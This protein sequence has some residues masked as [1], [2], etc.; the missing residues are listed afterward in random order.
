MTPPRDP[1]LQPDEVHVW[2]APL[3]VERGLAARLA[4]TL[5]SEEMAE[6][7]RFRAERHLGAFVAARGVLRLVLSAYVGE[8]PAALRV[9]RSDSGKPFLI[10]Y[11]DL[12]F[13][14]SHSGDVALYAVTHGREVGVD[15]EHVTS[16]D[17]M[18]MARRF[19]SRRE[20]DD[21]LMVAEPLRLSAFFACWTRKEAFLKATGEGLRRDLTTFDV[22]L[23]PGETPRLLEVRGMPGEAECWSLRSIDLGD[24]YQAA[25]AV[26]GPVPWIHSWR[27]VPPATGGR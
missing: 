2:V 4:T 25:V 24:T 13:N 9:A 12:R 6:A 5:S 15:V 20:Y 16:V 10:D 11:P 3:R 19:F 26:K 8:D 23:P 14:V 7:A 21:L 27:W 22:S 1:L 17:W 18:G